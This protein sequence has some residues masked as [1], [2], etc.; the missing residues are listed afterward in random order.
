M[1]NVTLFLGF[2]PL[3][4][5]IY[6]LL[7]TIIVIVLSLI[8]KKVIDIIF[9]RLKN[10]VTSKEMLSKTRTIRS[11]LKNTVDVL[12]FLIYIMMVLSNWGVNITPLL[13]GAGILGLGVSF[14]SQT[15]VKDILAGFFIIVEN[16]FNVGD[17]VKIKDYRGEVIGLTLRL[18][19][20]QDEAGNIIYIPNS[21]VSTVTVFPSA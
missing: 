9:K 14:G 6:T 13:T 2:I 17:V 12:L 16:Q 1:K 3:K 11:L 4:N 18:T 20:L 21:E 7:I 5:I 10:R 8:I 15:L 19:V